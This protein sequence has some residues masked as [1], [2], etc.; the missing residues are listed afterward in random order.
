MGGAC[1]INDYERNVY[2]IL[3]EARR[4]KNTEKKTKV[5]KYY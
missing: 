1:N 5:G 2:R 3:M 4:R